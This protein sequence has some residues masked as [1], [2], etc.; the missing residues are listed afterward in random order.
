MSDFRIPSRD[1]LEEQVL[2]KKKA[3]EGFHTEGGKKMIKR[4]KRLAWLGIEGKTARDIKA[5][6]R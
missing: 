2:S 6:I 3:G 1:L 5:S 4:T